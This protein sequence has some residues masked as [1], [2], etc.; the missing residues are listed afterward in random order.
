M[1]SILENSDTKNYK[2][3]AQFPNKKLVTIE[4]IPFYLKAFVYYIFINVSNAL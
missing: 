4:C 1:F 3:F 2:N